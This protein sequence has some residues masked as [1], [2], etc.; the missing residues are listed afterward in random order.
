[1]PEVWLDMAHIE[2]HRGNVAGQEAALRQA[3]SISPAWSLPTRTLADLYQGQGRFDDA[4]VLLNQALRHNPRDG[5]THGW[6]ADV[7]WMMDERD[8]ALEHLEQ[9]LHLKPGYLWAWDKLVRFSGEHH[10]EHRPLA[11]AQALTVNQ[12][13]NPNSWLLL[14]HAHEGLPAAM[15]AIERALMHDP[16]LLRA[17]EIR[18]DLLLRNGDY[19]E[20]YNATLSEVW[21]GNVPPGLRLRQARIQAQRGDKEEALAILKSL[22]AAE[23]DY[24]EAWEQ[25]AHWH[26]AAD[27]QPEHLEVSR[28]MV[29]LNPADSIAHGYLADAL[30]KNGDRVNSK[31]AL[32]RALT[33]DPGYIWG[34]HRLFDMELE[35]Q[36]VVAARRILAMIE[37][38]APAEN[39]A[40]ARLRLASVSKDSSAALAAFEALAWTSTEENEFFDRAVSVFKEAGEIDMFDG[41]LA[42]LIVQADINP[43]LGRVWMERTVAKNGWHIPGRKFE[44]LLERGAIGSSAAASYLR[45]M[46]N[47][48]SRW[49]LP[50]FLRK[51]GTRLHADIEIWG[52][53]GFALFSASLNKKCAHWLRDWREREGVRPWMLLNLALA[54]RDLKRHDEA[55]AVSEFAL[56]LNINDSLDQH[57][58]LLAI[59]AG[60]AGNRPR[61]TQLLEEIGTPEVSAYYRFLHEFSLAMQTILLSGNQEAA[62]RK[63]CQHMGKGISLLPYMGEKFLRQVHYR[64]LW[65]IALGRSTFL[66]MTT[67]WFVRARLTLIPYLTRQK[68]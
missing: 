13:R 23:P 53:G 65:R 54:L 42:R 9:A 4:R 35:D 15:A 67:L 28:E 34:L 14:A 36:D 58:L 6:L 55:H 64:T 26:D 41:L 48:R 27:R 24:K 20:A 39:A 3:L 2:R 47:V 29:R 66:P 62:F 16:I 68:A 43:Q 50:F 17:H 44:A 57:R 40:L 56:T 31:A 19:D 33:F 18:V 11:L 32:Q 61:L 38:H 51:Y 21:Q 8:S 1:L 46:G 60:L 37:T 63:A 5:I 30:F 52:L 49:I 22:L 10:Q 7:L 59:D 45:H 12:P 25:L